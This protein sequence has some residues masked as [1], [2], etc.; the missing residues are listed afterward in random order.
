MKF[1]DFFR[2]KQLG[3]ESHTVGPVILSNGVQLS[4]ELVPYLH[5]IEKSALPFIQIKASPEEK[6]SLTQSKFGGRG[7]WPT[8][9]PYPTDTNGKYLFLLAQ[10]N[11]EEVPPLPGY[12]QKGLLQFY[13]STND[14]MGLNFDDPTAQTGHRVIYFEEYGEAR[15]EKD[16]AFLIDVDFSFVPVN[17]SMGLAF[18]EQTDY[19]GSLDLRFEKNFG[20]DCMEFTERFG[21]KGDDVGEELCDNFGCDGHKIGGYACFTQSDPREQRAGH[22]EWI[23]LLQ[24]D[25]QDSDIVWGDAGIGNFFIHPEDLKKKDFSRVLYNWDCS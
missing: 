1:F 4:K 25:S 11:F 24:I 13:I 9:D 21:E 5:T 2:K 6:L 20:E 7:Y 23:L 15:A 3:E 18:Q 19:I 22:E 10:L 14:L 17:R 16:F 8:G 12:P